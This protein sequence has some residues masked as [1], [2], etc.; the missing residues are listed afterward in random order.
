MRVRFC[1]CFIFFQTDAKG[2]SAADRHWHPVTS[3][4]Y[5]MVIWRDLLTNT[6]NG[7]D[8]ILIWGKGSVFAF[9]QKEDG[10]WWLPERLV[11]QVDTDPE[12]SSKYDSNYE[13]D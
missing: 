10:A 4:F 12:S 8:P 5:A 11:R 1:L 9:S 7:T 6:W 3:S 13:D 2:Q